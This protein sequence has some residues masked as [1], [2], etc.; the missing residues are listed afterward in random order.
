MQVTYAKPFKG[1]LIC[2]RFEGGE[3]VLLDRDIVLQNNIDVGTSI[4]KERLL[5]L[6][7]ESDY[8]RAKSRALWYLDRSDH[9]EKALYDKLIK[10]KFSPKTCA[11]VLAKLCEYDLINDRRFAERYF[12]RLVEQNVSKRQAYYKL[13]EKGVPATLVKEILDNTEVDEETEI[14]NT[15]EKKYKNKLDTKENVQKVYNA[16]IRKGFSFGAVRNVLKNVAE[17]LKYASEEL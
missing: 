12:E 16:L 5:E 6:V 8:V 14:R 11:K 10:A 15:I 3:E 13:W 2:L 1:H 17:E 9:T 7:D 4:S